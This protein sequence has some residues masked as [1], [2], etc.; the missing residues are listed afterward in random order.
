[1]MKLREGDSHNIAE[2]ENANP[3]KTE[4]GLHYEEMVSNRGVSS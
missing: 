3:T 1:M 4:P 2:E